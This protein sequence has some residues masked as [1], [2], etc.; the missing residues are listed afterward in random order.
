M[1][2]ES[3]ACDESPTGDVGFSCESKHYVPGSKAAT[4]RVVALWNSLPRLVLKTSGT[5]RSFLRSIVTKPYS[6]T[7]RTSLQDRATGAARDVWPIPPPYPEVFRGGQS[8]PQDALKRLVNL[9]VVTLDWLH[10]GCPSAA[11]SFL[12][13]GRRLSKKQWIAVRNLQRLSRDEN[14]PEFID[15]TLMGRAAAKFEGLDETL[16]NL[17]S[18]MVEMHDGLRGYAVSRD[19]R[20]TVHEDQWMKCGSLLHSVD[21][22]EVIA[23]KPIVAS[24]L[25][26]PAAPSFDP[27]K[28]FDAPTAEVYL[29]PIDN[30]VDYEIFDGEVPVVK[31][32]A[33][34]AERLALFRKLADTGRLKPV[35]SNQ[36]RGQ[37]VSGL[38]A[39]GKNESKDRLIL[40]ARP[41]NLLES[42]KGKWCS[43]MAAGCCLS[44]VVLRPGHSLLAS[45]LDLTDYFYQFVISDQRVARNILAG[46][47]SLAQAREVFGESFHWQEEPVLVSLSTLAMGDLLACEFAQ[48]AHLGL[49]LRHGACTPT[50]LLS[51]RL[52]VP[53]EP[54]MTGI[55]IDDLVVL[56]QVA[57]NVLA[58]D[59]DEKFAADS[60]IDAA[61]RGYSEENLLH[62]EKKTFRNSS[63]SRFWGIELDGMAGLVR[64]S[65]MRM[66][67]LVFISLRVAMMGFAT[68]KLMECLSGCWIAILTC[69]RRMLCLME[70]I[71]E[72]L[73]MDDPGRVIRLSTEMVDELVSLSLLAPLAVS[74]LRAQFLPFVGATDASGDWMAAVRAPLD[75]KVVQE[76]ARHSLKKGNWSKLLPPEKAWLRLHSSLDPDEELPGDSYNS[77]PLW[78]TL[79]CC[80]T[81]EERWRQPAKQGQHINILEL[82][83][84]LR[85]ER[86]VS[87]SYS[88][89]RFLCGIDSQVTLGAVVKGRAASPSLNRLLKS[90]LCYPLGAALFN[91]YMYYASETNR[92]DG[93]TRKSTPAPP[94]LPMPSWMKEIEAGNFEG[95]D[96][97]MSEQERGVVDAPFDCKDLMGSETMDLRPASQKR[98]SRKSSFLISPPQKTLDE[99]P[100]PSFV[101]QR[102]EKKEGRDLPSDNNPKQEP[103]QTSCTSEV[104]EE[105][106]RLLASI[107]SQQFFFEGE[108]LDF[109][110]A[111]ALDLFSGCFGVAK[112]LSK[113]KAP[114]VLTYEWKRSAGEDLLCPTVR[115]TIK[116]LLLSGAIRSLSMAPICCSFS[117]AITPPIRSRRYPRGRPNVSAAMKRK[118][119]EGNSHLDFMMELI[120][121]SEEMSIS[122][123]LENPDTSWMWRQRS[124]KKFRDPKS[125]NLF[126]LSFCRF[127]TAWKKNTRI[128][129][130]TKLAGLRMLCSCQSGHHQLRG[131]SK[132]HKRSWTSV[133]EP[134]P[135]GLSKLLALALAVGAGWCD[136]KRL[137]VAQCAK[138]GSLRAGEA[139]NPG[140]LRSRSQPCRGTLEDLP[141]LLPGT[142]EMEARLLKEFVRWCSSTLPTSPSVFDRVPL[143]MGMVLRSYGDLLFQR[144]G[145]LAN[146]RHL[147][148][149]CQRWK[150]ACRPFTG[151]AWE[152][153]RRWEIQEPV[154][155]R[156]PL[157]EGILK[158]FCAVAW[159]LG[160]FE[161]AGVCLISFYGAGR[162]GEVIRCRRGDLILPA[163]TLEDDIKAAFLQ[164]RTFKSQNRQKAKIQHMKISNLDAVKIISKVFRLY[165][166]QELLFHGSADQFRKRWDYI[167]GLFQIP[168]SARL[169]PGGL[170]GGAAVAA[171]R[172]GKQINEIQW[173]LRLRSLSTLESYLQ[174]T[175]TLTVH[176]KLDE[177]CR[178]RLSSASKLYPFLAA[179]IR[180]QD[181]KSLPQA[182]LAGSFA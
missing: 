24:R 173:S 21:S 28:F 95:F 107:P 68:I 52:P 129:T 130:S 172:S 56:E 20:P 74:D 93:P 147:I 99:A 102:D 161:W 138:L 30:A 139:K 37:F 84:F 101:P 64:A 31:V 25:S 175:G 135:H 50:N 42:P 7:M 39:V 106:Q 46:S 137:N 118:L 98:R 121:I 176:S 65:S 11:P 149:A 69:R 160:W 22:K 78:T 145:S 33:V 34:T 167:L 112:E 165:P 123:T 124:T 67:P 97:W 169:T 146:F 108:T 58:G 116:K 43:S 92:A 133:A 88:S 27:I 71:F 35:T 120:E 73:G 48:S 105:A 18:S 168:R 5:L 61:L 57:L 111:G 177:T 148:L 132:V 29:R 80:L 2:Y 59:V 141:G 152:L 72:P 94:S 113:L 82:K 44:D 79:A 103:C 170:R 156:P 180:S 12:Q 110:R 119:G 26:F 9:E 182:E 166:P 17:A 60:L 3:V 4:V 47:L 14:T 143:F 55:V 90:S 131:Y 126:R 87:K 179:R 16:R 117:V 142:L 70:K 76:V 114:W 10:L 125:P 174:E 153:V 151:T 51:F 85:E 49:C 128:A 136:A 66:W 140:P 89:A 157:P 178:Q 171:Y 63:K 36:K 154:N 86:E 150:P 6:N 62:N 115:G 134:Y 127:G 164:L 15:S 158:A 13:L 23:A 75:A 83:S 19:D 53:R 122:Y 38:F 100:R 41:P 104:P 40:D 144:N 155:H 45:G 54:T 91:Y 81:F 181:G 1:K 163:D 77:H 159:H 8:G 32:N 96:Q 109:K 162:L